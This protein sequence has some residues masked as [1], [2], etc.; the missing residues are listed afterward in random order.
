MQNKQADGITTISPYPFASYVELFLTGDGKLISF[1]PEATR[2]SP[3]EIP[4]I[5][6]QPSLQVP[7][8]ARI[9]TFKP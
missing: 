3:P 6:K 2:N 1:D 8:K 9:K 5:L 4:H 7:T